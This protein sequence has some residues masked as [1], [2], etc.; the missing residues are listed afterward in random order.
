MIL[1]VDRY[2][3]LEQAYLDDGCAERS[4]IHFSVAAIDFQLRFTMLCAAAALREQDPYQVQLSRAPGFGTYQAFLSK[5]RSIL[6]KSGYTDFAAVIRL[7]DE[8][9]AAITGFNGRDPRFGSL[10]RLRNEL[11]HA[12]V[13]PTGADLAALRDSVLAVAKQISAA[14]RGFLTGAEIVTRPGDADLG[15]VDFAWA[16]RRLSMWPFLCADRSGR[17]CV[18]AQ[19]NSTAPTYLRAGS[20]DVTVKGGGDELI[21]DLTAVMRP[22]DNDRFGH[23]VADI[24]LDLAG[25]RDADHACHH[26]EVDGMVA[27]LW[28]RATSEGTE[29]RTDQFRLGDGEQ[30]QWLNPGTGEWCPY[31]DFLR[32][33]V[34]WPVAVA[35]FR[36][37]LEKI[38]EELLEGER[39][40][41]AWTKGAG[42]YIKPTFRVTG[43]QNSS[44]KAEPMGIDELRAEIDGRLRLRG[45]KSRIYFVEG[46]AGIGK[47]RSL[48]AT[49]LERAREIEREPGSTRSQDRL[50]LLYYVR[51]TGQASNSLD[52]VIDAAATKTK[53]LEL[54]NIKALCRNGLIALVVDGLDEL[55]G[56]VGYDNALGSLRQWIEAMAGRGVIVVSA[57][58]SYYVNQYSESIRRDREQLDIV[59]EHRVATVTEWDDDQLAGFLRQHGV[60]PVRAERLSRED[61]KLLGLPFFARVYAEF[62]DTFDENSETLPDL[63]LNQYIARESP[64]LV[65]GQHRPLLD[66]TQLRATFERLAVAMAERGAREADLDDLE[67]AALAATGLHDITLIPGL[68]DRLSTLCALKVSSSASADKRFSFQHELFYD[69]FLADAILRDLHADD[70]VHV[71]TMM[72]TVQWRA[73]TV[74]RVTR[75]GGENV[76]LLFTVEP[77]QLPDDLHTSQRRTFSANLGALLAS[78]ARS[79]G[80]VTETAVVQ[81]TFGALDLIGVAVDGVRFERCEFETLRL[82]STGVRG[83]EFIDCAIGTLFVETGGKPLKCVTAFENTAVAQLV[84]PTAFLEKT[85][86]V[87]QALY[88]LGAPVTRVKAAEPDS[89]FADAVEFFLDNIRARVD[90]VVVYE[91]TLTPAEEN[92]RWQNEYGMDQW[93]AFI[94]IL[95]DT[96]CAKLVPFSAGGPPVLRVK[97]LSIEKLRERVAQS[98]SSPIALFW[99]AVRRHKVA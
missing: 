77:H 31:P 11:A 56:G 13:M 64:K 38:E 86:A 82:P 79:T 20:A 34:N 1:A 33:I 19:F 87:R 2:D 37:Y 42:V 94:R 24:Q 76:E 39:E 53:N 83:L 91:R 27:I 30:R 51:S 99:Q 93:V 66:V 65:D 45:S 48:V 25:F 63:L 90:T 81:A 80:E 26:Y 15:A 4:T 18:F 46:E 28:F 5:A 41:L 3:E 55:L 44:R 62:A 89:E 73:A 75:E 57:R 9:F 35:R 23:F 22:L 74:S 95:R 84:R 14:I 97:I 68:R 32:D 6:H 71:L 12:Q 43:L 16:D 47:T 8:V 60:D 49:A 78:H 96:E 52:T 59:V 40:G 29:A 70:F 85:H 69:I 92:I 88:E 67:H 50:P 7:V 61:R 36:Q 72:A 54:E 58:S 21:I 17:L 10:T 98:S